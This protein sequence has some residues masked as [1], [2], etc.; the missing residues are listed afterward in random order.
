MNIIARQNLMI[1]Q[2][3]TN[4]C[5]EFFCK[6][7]QKKTCNTINLLLYFLL[8]I[9]ILNCGSDNGYKPEEKEAAELTSEGWT[10]FSYGINSYNKALTTFNEAI[11]LDSTYIE[12]YSGAGWTNARLTNLTE[13]LTYLNKCISLNS[14]F[15]DAHAGKAFIY[16]AQKEYQKSIES[17]NTTLIKDK[18]WIFSHDETLSYHDI[19]LIIAEGYF[20]V[21]DYSRSLNQIQILNP[22]F[23]ADINSKAGIAK[24]SAEIERLHGII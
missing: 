11:A 13:A 18:N 3:V 2:T 9:F 16:N 6:K 21:G 5:K 17:G 15:V 10:L 4:F 23:S 19:H 14:S 1:T 12:A 24:L 8:T 7:I 20:G 22:E